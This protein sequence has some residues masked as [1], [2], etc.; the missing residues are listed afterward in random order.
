M[1]DSFSGRKVYFR[2]V[3]YTLAGFAAVVTLIF[4]FVKCS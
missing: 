2:Q 3:M 1:R 4:C